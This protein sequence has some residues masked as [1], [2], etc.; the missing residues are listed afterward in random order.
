[1]PGGD[2]DVWRPHRDRYRVRFAGHMGYA[3]IA[4]AAGVPI[5]PVANAGAHD[6]LYVLSDGHRLASLLRL[7]AI[8]RAH[9]WPLHLSLPWGLAFGPWPHIPL[10]VTLR[11]RMGPAIYPETNSS[12][13]LEQQVVDLDLRV[14][15]GVQAQLDRL[16]V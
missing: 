3:R 4:I 5:V 10:P 14:R 9:I 15:K 1:M 6:T 12:K 13:S 16:A 2:F 8:V 11:Y 7:P